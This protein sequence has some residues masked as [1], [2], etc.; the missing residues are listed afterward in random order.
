M[1]AAARA[2]MPT[3]IQSLLRSARG[4]S[5]AAVNDPAAVPESSGAAAIL[6][7]LLGR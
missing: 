4:G 7:R 1:P 2:T 3:K 6:G 5:S